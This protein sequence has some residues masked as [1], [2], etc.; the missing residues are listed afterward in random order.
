MGL[1]DKLTDKIFK[2]T[3]K[4]VDGILKPNKP[5]QS[6][7]TGPV[8]TPVQAAAPVQTA[9]VATDAERIYDEDGKYEFNDTFN[10]DTAYFRDIIQRNFADYVIEEG[11]SISRFDASAHPK[12]T[13]VT[14]LLT[15]GTKTVA[16]FVMKVNQT[17]GMPYRGAK[18]VLRAAGIPSIHCISN[19]K[20]EEAYVVNRIRTIL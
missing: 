16:F 4:A 20:N 19:Y 1:F 10:R 11:V 7:Q 6:T 3:Q 8:Q 18:Q 2:E 13:P 12:C 14:F 15:K 5:A 17:A 9:T